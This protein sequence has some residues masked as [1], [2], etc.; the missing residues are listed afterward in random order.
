MI[1][2][3]SGVETPFTVQIED[4]LRREIAAWETLRNEQQAT[5]NW[6]FAT[7]DAR[8]RVQMSL[9]KHITTPVVESSSLGSPWRVGDCVPSLAAPRYSWHGSRPALCELCGRVLA[10]RFPCGGIGATGK[11]RRLRREEWF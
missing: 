4:A 3:G 1:F 6:C 10:A 2:L 7:S 9:S 11:R 8:A 5:V